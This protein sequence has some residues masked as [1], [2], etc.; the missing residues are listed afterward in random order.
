MKLTFSTIGCP[1]WTLDEMIAQGAAYGFQ[2]VELGTRDD[3]RH[4]PPDTSLETARETGKRFR[5]SGLPVLTISGN[6]RFAFEE[7]EAIQKNENLL[8]KLIDLAEAFKAP[9][10]RV[11]TGIMPKGANRGEMI[12]TVS[13]AFRPL[14]QKA[15]DQG[16]VLALET[17]DDW[18]SAGQVMPIV[19]RVDSKAFQV[20]YDVQNSIESGIES[21]ENTYAGLKDHIAYLHIKDAYR[22]YAGKWIHTPLGAGDFPLETLLSRL[23]ADGYDGTFSFEWEKMWCPDLEPPERVFP[24]FVHK[25]KTVWKSA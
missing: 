13:T 21:W 3:G 24:Q 16:V 8:A 4:F 17:H 20:L 1:D 2:G 22:N 19:E 5:D 11:F 10:V 15:L 6:S 7:E 9:Y 25:I 23:K 12:E 14:A 18:C